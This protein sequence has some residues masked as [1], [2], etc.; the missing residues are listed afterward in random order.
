MKTKH[1]A[2]IFPFLMNDYL[3]ISLDK[4]WIE[5]CKGIPKFTVM[6]NEEGRLCILGP[7]IDATA[8]ATHE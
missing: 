6:I 1:L 3:V 2:T 4:Q 5:V 8:G 7:V